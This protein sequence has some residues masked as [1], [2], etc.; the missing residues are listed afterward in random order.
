MTM[1][2]GRS[3]GDRAM[4]ARRGFLVV[5]SFALSGIALAAGELTV[6]AGELKHP[7]VEQDVR[8]RLAVEVRGD[9]E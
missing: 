7:Q 2:G 6:V 4:L 3:L 1:C 8:L 9:E 5:A